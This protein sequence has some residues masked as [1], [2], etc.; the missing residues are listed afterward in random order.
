VFLTAATVP[1]PRECLCTLYTSDYESHKERNPERVPGTC[2]WFLKNENYKNWRQERISSLLWVS[3]NPGCGKSVLASFLVDELSSPESQSTLSATIC[4]FFFKDDNDQQ[5]NAAFALCALLHQLFTKKKSLISHAML[6]FENKGHKFTEEFGTLWDIFTN[7]VTDINCGNV[8][9]VID[10][11]DECE[12]PTRTSLIRSLIKFYSK[13][14]DRRSTNSFL[15]FIVTSRPYSSIEREFNKHPTIRLKAED[16]TNEINADIVRVIRS[17]VESIG[18]D[19]GLSIAVRTSLKERLIENADQTFLWVS[20][21][22]E[23]IEES[24]RASRKALD[25]I[26]SEIPSTLDAIYEKILQKSSNHKD[27]RKLLQ[28]VVAAA[29]PLTLREINIAFSLTPS[30]KSHKELDPELEPSIESTVKGLCGLFIRVI[31][32]KVYLVH[33]TAR[34]FLIKKPNTNATKSEARYNPRSQIEHRW[35]QSVDPIES[36]FILANIC[37]HYLLFEDFETDPLEKICRVGVYTTKYGFLDYTANHWAVH[38]REAR[39]ADK[40]ELLETALKLYNTNSNRFLTWF[41]IYW[42]KT[43]FSPKPRFTQDWNNLMIASYFGHEVVVRRLLGETDV[44]TKGST[45]GSALNAA[46][47]GKH[48]NVVEALLYEG[49]YV[50]LYSGEY[51]DLT[52]V[53][54]AIF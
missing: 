6:D 54:E 28:I 38:F 7:A 24:A 40:S 14:S 16:K 12:E 22:L 36:N 27:A 18:N 25:D 48:H 37:V 49:A 15:K 29:R 10:G 4:H 51:K 39:I 42:Y 35:K 47:F 30:V 20:L 17:K 50:Y 21:V 2:E 13:D 44:N 1:T 3:A 46:A 53:S 26:I 19:K 23:M 41:Q 52:K 43:E 9:C 34:E 11:L 5:K 45:Y 31:N 33:L 32:S 8:I